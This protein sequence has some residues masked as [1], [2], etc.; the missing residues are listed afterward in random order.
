MMAMLE[1]IDAARLAFLMNKPCVTL[2]QSTG[3]NI[4]NTTNTQLTWNSAA[5]DIWGGWSSSNPSRWTVPVPGW[6]KLQTTIMWPGNATGARH[7][8]FYQNGIENTT[9]TTDWGTP[10]GSMQFPHSANPVIVQANAGDY[11]QVNLWQASGV[12]LTS[13]TPGTFVITFER[14]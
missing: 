6:Y 11:F 7:V 1:I 3:Q 2:V 10:P 9:S 14:F 13:A 12:T 5:G 8:E 4:P